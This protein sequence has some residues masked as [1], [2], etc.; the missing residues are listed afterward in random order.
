MKIQLM[1]SPALQGVELRGVE[2]GDEQNLPRSHGKSSSAP[3][4][5]GLSQHRVGTVCDRW[6]PGILTAGTVSLGPVMPSI[7]PSD[8]DL[9]P[10]ALP[11]QHTRALHRPWLP[12]R[13]GTR[14]VPP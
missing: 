7:L 5:E 10:A 3:L 1:E 13:L 6:G 11:P 2:V 8:Q 4:Q 12:M 14:N 9:A